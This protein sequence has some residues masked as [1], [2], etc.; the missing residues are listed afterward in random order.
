MERQKKI[1]Q[2]SILGILVNIAL[3]L[4]KAL[5]GYLTSS[6]AIVM[7]AVNNLGDAF[8]SLVTIVGTKLAG[9]KA[10]K[11]H[12]FGYG[13]IEYFTSF[14]IGVV[15]LIA[16]CTAL[17]E[18]IVKVIHPVEAK[19][20]AVSLIMIIVAIVAKLVT[21]LYVKKTGIKINAKTLEDSGT[22]SIM[23]SLVSLTTLIAAVINLIFGWSLEG[24]LGVLISILVIKSGFEMV[25]DTVDVLLGTKADL[26]LS[27][28]I[29]QKIRSIEG[30]NG[31]YDLILHNYGPVDMIGSVHVEVDDSFT[32]RQIHS[33]SRKIVQEIYKDYGIVMTVGIYASNKTDAESVEI[34]DTIKEQIKQYSQI[35]QV[36]GFY[37]NKELN[38]IS[39]DMVI[40]F[41]EEN[42]KQIKNEIC[43]KMH[44]LYPLYTFYANLDMD[45][46][47]ID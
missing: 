8:S 28:E 30:V 2:T 34:L 25:K 29:K 27:R 22:D 47:S 10:D 17:K 6:V 43:D 5:L 20:T 19:Y 42:A 9:L 18:S 26:T 21:G 15:V 7:D 1:I 33:L 36:H 32:A 11:K 40:E 37:I 12:P 44:Q 3:V 16:G 4:L 39:F 46:S 14:I 24:Y 13:R 38:T 31:A 45:Y 35:K 41:E 23:D